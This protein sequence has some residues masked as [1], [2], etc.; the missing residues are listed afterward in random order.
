MLNS[1]RV[2]SISNVLGAKPL[3]QMYSNWLSTV[4]LSTLSDKIQISQPI[5]NETSNCIAFTLYFQYIL[6]C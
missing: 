4:Y 3:K 1:N 5:G 6:D 2:R